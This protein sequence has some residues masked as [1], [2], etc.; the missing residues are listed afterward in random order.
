[1][2]IRIEPINE[3]NLEW[4]GAMLRDY[5]IELE[6]DDYNGREEAHA[7]DVGKWLDKM[8]AEAAE[9]KIVYWLAYHDDAPLGFVVFA[10]KESDWDGRPYGKLHEFY[11]LPAMRGGGNGRALAQLAFDEMAQRGATNVEL[12]VLL[13]NVGGL[14]FW[15]SLGV[16]INHYVL[17]MPLRKQGDT[18]V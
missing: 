15:Q 3:A 11:I 9:G 13:S 18:R 8:Y 2:Q 1:M 6:P 10:T 4:A 14:A 16:K 5:S 12:G 7:A 17:S